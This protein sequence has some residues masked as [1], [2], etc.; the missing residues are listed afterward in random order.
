M[1][2]WW[3]P[4]GYVVLSDGT[5]LDFAS[6]LHNKSTMSRIWTECPDM[7]LMEVFIR[8]MRCGCDMKFAHYARGPKINCNGNIFS[9]CRRKSCRLRLM[10]EGLYKQFK[11][12]FINKE[13]YTWF[14]MFA[15]WLHTLHNST[16]A[17]LRLQSNSTKNDRPACTWRRLWAQGIVPHGLP[18]EALLQNQFKSCKIADSTFTD[19]MD[20]KIK[21]GKLNGN[22]SKNKL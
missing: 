20:Y 17:S 15:S 4:T 10:I 1:R 7:V 19:N 2:K 16:H 6:T 22:I 13:L 14:F 9:A 8:Q 11:T 12:W 3:L 5:I 18:K 21:D